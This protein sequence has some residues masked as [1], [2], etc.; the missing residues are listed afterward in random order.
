MDQIYR[1]PLE[2]PEL[3]AVNLT[4]ASVYDAKGVKIGEVSHVYGEGLAVEVIVDIGGSLLIGPK[5]VSLVASQLEFT[6]EEN[7][8][9]HVRVCL[10][11][12][13]LASRIQDTPPDRR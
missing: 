9:V 7:S 6:R 13:E 11:E 5:P 3:N 8:L 1:M 12:V 4:G 2:A 10:S